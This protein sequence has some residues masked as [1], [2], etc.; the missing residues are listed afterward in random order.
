MESKDIKN[1]SYVNELHWIRCPRISTPVLL[2]V[3]WY[4]LVYQFKMKIL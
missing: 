4:G 3:Y 1:S 2:R